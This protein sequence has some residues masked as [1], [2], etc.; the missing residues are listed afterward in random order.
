[1]RW[2]HSTRRRTVYW[3]AGLLILLGTAATQASLADDAKAALERLGRLGDL[4]AAN[5]TAAVRGVSQSLETMVANAV[6]PLNQ[7]R[8]RAES[9]LATAESQ[10]Q[11]AT[12]RT[13][14]PPNFAA[15]R[16]LLATATAAINAVEQSRRTYAVQA[17]AKAPASVTDT[18][19][20]LRSRLDG[21]VGTLRGLV[22]PPVGTRP[23]TKASRCRDPIS[24]IEVDC[25]VPN[26][27]PSDEALR[28][29]INAANVVIGDVARAADIAKVRFE[30][31][32]RADRT[33]VDGSI[34][35]AAKALADA[36]KACHEAALH[37]ARYTR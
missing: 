20:T 24:K 27:P 16:Q 21:A 8:T 17:A 9:A 23:A 29:A 12:T 6:A 35:T 4:G 2:P 31:L 36:S 15:A 13:G 11:S 14:S 10:W 26:P 1:M 5:A 37:V 33:R 32:T 34:L 18:T 7:T 22:P 19:A 30:E 3:V 25:T 28:A